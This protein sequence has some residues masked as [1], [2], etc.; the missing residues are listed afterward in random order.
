MPTN[1]E[2]ISL[3]SV[4]PGEVVAVCSS[5]VKQM[6]PETQICGILI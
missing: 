3:H 5:K 4:I 6:G 2:E 1:S